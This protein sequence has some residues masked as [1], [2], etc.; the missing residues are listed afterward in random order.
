MAI[1][2]RLN[3]PLE[4]LSPS[5]ISSNAAPSPRRRTNGGRLPRPSARRSCDNKG[6]KLQTSIV[7]EW[8]LRA[9]NCRGHR[10]DDNLHDRR[11]NV[12]LETHCT[13]FIICLSPKLFSPCVSAI[14]EKL[15]YSFMVRVITLG[16]HYTWS[17]RGMPTVHCFEVYLSASDYITQGCAQPELT[18]RIIAS[19]NFL[20]N[21][22]QVGKG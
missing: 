22:P 15:Y 21:P 10:R 4:V 20:K 19:G 14:K 18:S 3:R 2:E 16:H 1:E 17:K 11:L 8:V 6:I 7:R 12:L 13:S 9:D 5:A